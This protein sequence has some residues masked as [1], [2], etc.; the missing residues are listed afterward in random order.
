M[1]SF[2]MTFILLF[3]HKTFSLCNISL[4]LLWHDLSFL[5]FHS[6]RCSPCP[7][8]CCCPSP[9]GLPNWTCGTEKKKKLNCV[10][11][12]VNRNLSGNLIRVDVIY[13]SLQLQGEPSL[14]LRDLN[15][16]IS[17]KIRTPF[18]IRLIYWSFTYN[19]KM[20][21]KSVAQTNKDTVP[22][23]AGEAVKQATAHNRLD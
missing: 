19:V 15:Q 8:G 21:M 17:L 6:L 2:S 7:N 23:K 10:C 3:S 13:H 5:W 22:Y 18:V 4:L 14:V 20:S 16:D 11:I 12:G 1:L 9:A